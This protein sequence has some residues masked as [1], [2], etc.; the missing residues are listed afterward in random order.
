MTTKR[1]AVMVGMKYYTTG[2]PCKHGHKAARFV[3][4]DMCVACMDLKTERAR[5]KFRN[6]NRMKDRAGKIRVVSWIHPDD[7]QAIEDFVKFLNNRIFTHRCLSSV[8][9]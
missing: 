1:D 9:Y 2:K 3:S 7:K 8:Y 5:K 4:N 6:K